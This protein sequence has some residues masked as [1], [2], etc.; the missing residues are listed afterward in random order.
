MEH[1]R[2]TLSQGNVP[3]TIILAKR[4]RGK[5]QMRRYGILP[6]LVAL[7]FAA[8]VM[9]LAGSYNLRAQAGTEPHGRTIHPRALAFNSATHRLYAVDQDGNR[10]IVVDSKGGRSSIAAGHAPNCLVVDAAV[11][12]IYVANAGSGDISVID[13]ATDRVVKTLP[14]EQ[15]PYGIAFDSALH[16]AYVTNTYSNKVTMI[17]TAANSVEQ[18]PV[19]S[20]DYV[21]TDAHRKR[22]FFISYEDPALTILDATNTVRH[23][24]LG[25][26]HPWGLAVDEQRGIVYV[27]E[28]GRNTLLA[29]H[30]ESGK[31]DKVP[32]GAMP[33][34]VAID[35]SA[36]KIYVTNYV[37]DSVTIIDGAAMKPV[38]TV[39]AGH[40]P[41]AVAV[42]GKRHRVFIANTHSDNATVIDG[43]TNRALA[44]VAAGTN[45]Y[46]VAVDPDNGDAYV[47][48]Y[49]SHPVTKLD[50]SSL[51]H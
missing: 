43:A 35:E 30:E 42:D 36:N 16:R 48:N 13:G 51:P 40:H 24:D 9:L 37:G 27:T 50:L 32:T 3:K 41:Q 6:N 26:S 31:T 17:D 49:G 22:A 21:E 39:A 44:T 7:V 45:P 33:D 1:K 15:H 12:R 5:T 23:E 25:L 2:Y 11:N 38:A 19:G 29:Y 28:I 47:A 4:R 8:S 14:G 20:K 18:L 10:V 34:A 46:A